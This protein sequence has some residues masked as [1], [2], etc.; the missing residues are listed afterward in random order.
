MCDEATRDLIREV[1][2]EAV[3]QQESF[4][5]YQISKRVQIRQKEK[6]LPFTRH[7]TIRNDVHR[8]LATYL[9]DGSYDRQLVQV[10][11]DQQAYLY[12]P[13]GSP[14]MADSVTPTD[15]SAPSDEPVSDDSRL[16]TSDDDGILP[17][18]VIQPDPRE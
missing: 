14:P 1:S 8:E 10:T 15:T 2:A 13:M 9:R 11:P 12:F 6:G 4:T 5:A 3:R 18:G 7:L 17:N 16:L